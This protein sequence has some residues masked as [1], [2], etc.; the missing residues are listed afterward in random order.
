[1]ADMNGAASLDA[2]Q[3]GP[4]AAEARRD[5]SSREDSDA[6]VRSTSEDN[7]QPSERYGLATA[8]GSQMKLQGGSGLHESS[9]TTQCLL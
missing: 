5:G 4:L 3:E 7:S 1:M 6:T 2:M 9:L 8:W